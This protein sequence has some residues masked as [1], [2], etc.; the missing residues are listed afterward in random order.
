MQTY[1]ELVLLKYGKLAKNIRKNVY[2]L[3]L[4][5]SQLHGMPLFPDGIVFTLSFHVMRRIHQIQ[6]KKHI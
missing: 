2:E 6:L 1:T 5:Y 3:W 4:L